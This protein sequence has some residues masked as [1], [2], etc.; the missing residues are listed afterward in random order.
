M[1][2]KMVPVNTSDPNFGTIGERLAAERERLGWSQIDLRLQMGVSKGTQI[3]YESGE[4]SPTADYL[5]DL[6]GKGFDVLYILTGNRD[7]S[8][9]S[10]E[11]QNLIEAYDDAPEA[12]KRAVFAALV[13][14]SSN[15]IRSS[16][17]HARHY[18]GYYRH[19]IRGESDVRYQAAREAGFAAGR[20]GETAERKPADTD[21]TTPSNEE[22][23]LVEGFRAMDERGRAGVLGLVA[24]F[25][26]GP[27]QAVA[28][29]ALP[30]EIAPRGQTSRSKKR[31]A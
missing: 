21:D 28:P 27:G 5:V 30:G 24:A 31:E 20:A 15:V 22:A 2:A 19:E 6:I 1:V 13:V 29:D 16:V 3:R 7:A 17:D 11:H 26:S 23:R 25:A 14:Q 18:P 10:D 12:L 4:T 9:L 8:A